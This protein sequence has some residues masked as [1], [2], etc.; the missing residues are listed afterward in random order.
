MNK[1][2]KKKQ[3]RNT[4]SSSLLQKQQRRFCKCSMTCKIHSTSL[5]HLTDTCGSVRNATF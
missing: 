1:K 3:K 5:L 4:P 2:A